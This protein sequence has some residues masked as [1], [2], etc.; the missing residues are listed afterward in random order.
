MGMGKK[1]SAPAPAPAPAPVAAATV[2]TK[3]YSEAQAPA[4]AA[5]NLQ[6]RS[7]QNRSATLLQ[8]DEAK[9]GDAKSLATNQSRLAGED[10]EEFLKRSNSVQ[11]G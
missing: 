6:A 7:E 5:A 11:L 1:K 8:T 10:E 4:N 3:D 9:K 2:E